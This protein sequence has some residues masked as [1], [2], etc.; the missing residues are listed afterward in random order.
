MRRWTATAGSAALGLLV[1][2]TCESVQAGEP[3]YTYPDEILDLGR[4][5]HRI[6]Q[7]LGPGS[8]LTIVALGS[9]STAGAGASRPEATYPVRLRERLSSLLAQPVNVLNRGRNGDRVGDMLFRL[10]T[11]VLSERPDAVIWQFGTNA[12]LTDLDGKDLGS[13]FSR[14]KREIAD[15]GAELIV[16]D[17]QFAPKVLAR[18]QAEDLVRLIDDAAFKV[19]RHSSVGSSLCGSGMISVSASSSSCR[20]TSCT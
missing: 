14:G 12:L 4:A 3:Q 8:S 10:P 16:M 7:R 18:R 15:A 5:L 6:S 2:A 11:D 19:A 20:P 9:S 17:P 13:L 1:L